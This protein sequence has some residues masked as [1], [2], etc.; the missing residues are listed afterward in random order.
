MKLRSTSEFVI[1]TPP[2]RL[3][4]VLSY[5]RVGLMVVPSNAR[6]SLFGSD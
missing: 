1:A 6:P 3:R 5:P 2:R 4:F